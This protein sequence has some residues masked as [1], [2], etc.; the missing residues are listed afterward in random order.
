Q[1]RV[2]GRVERV[3][4]KENE[5]HWRD[6]EGKR[7]IAAFEQSEPIESREALEALVARVPE[8]PPRPEFWVGYRVV[9]DAFEF[10][11]AADDF[12][13]DRFRYERANGRWSRTRLQP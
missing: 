1:V 7:E 10:W 4:D 9:P 5:E 11:T 13:H 12:V 8:D 3:A 6:R 2:E